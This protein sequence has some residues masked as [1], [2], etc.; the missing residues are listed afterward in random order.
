MSSPTAPAGLVPALAPLGVKFQIVL[1]L[2]YADDGT[3][4]SITA[5]LKPKEGVKGEARHLQIAGPLVEVEQQIAEKLPAAVEAIT[6][7]V[8]NLDTLAAELAAEEQAAKEKGE[9][10]K[11]KAAPSSAKKPEPKKS[12][13]KGKGAG[14]KS[15]ADTATE[16]DDETPTDDEG[17]DATPSPAPAAPATGGKTAA[18]AAILNLGLDDEPAL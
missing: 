13:A 6:R 2:A 15:A 18:E 11:K 9:A 8:T 16:T 10:D 1:I 7:H 17:G 5:H 4:V 14:S 12:P 3:G